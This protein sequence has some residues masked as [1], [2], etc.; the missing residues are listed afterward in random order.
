[1]INNYN[2]NSLSI[3][4]PILNENKNLINLTKNIFKNTKGIRYEIIFVDDNSKDGSVNTLR[5]LKKKYKNL[6][7]FIRKNDSDLTK[8][9]FLGITKSKYNFNL[10]MDGDGQH[11]P[12]YIKPMLNTFIKK[13]ADF[14]IGARK[15]D[16]I[17]ES[18]SFSRFL[19]SKI[20]IFLFKI[21]FKLKTSD[22]MTG[23]FIFKKNFYIENKKYFFGRGYKILADL[24]YSTPHN[25]KIIDLKINFLKRKN[26][27]SKMSYKILLI[28]ILFII[29]RTIKKI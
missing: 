26:E 9:C 20:L 22:P 25:L 5:Y 23:F 4:I 21:L 18:L 14:V 7:F 2:K 8:S 28:L 11:N 12:K 27:K 19:A 1:M 24:I 16:D 3:I 17:N 15:F 6:R 10:I 13:K 29:S